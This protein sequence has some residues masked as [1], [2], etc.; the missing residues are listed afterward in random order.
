MYVKA[1][2]LCVMI[3]FQTSSDQRRSAFCA[4]AAGPHQQQ[5]QASAEDLFPSG[6]PHT[7]R[8]ARVPECPWYERAV[9]SVPSTG[10]PP[11]LAQHRAHFVDDVLGGEAKLL[12]VHSPGAEAPNRSMPMM[13]P[14]EA[15]VALPALASARLRWRGASARPAAA[16]PAGSRLAACRRAPT[17]ACSPRGC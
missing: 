6:H 1:T 3:G 7:N 4:W 16:R 9:R 8:T 15:D 12:H 13:R 10:A 2:P 17:T 5:R 14:V 11:R